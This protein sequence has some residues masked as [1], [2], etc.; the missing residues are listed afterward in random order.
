MAHTI[1]GVKREGDNEVTET[2]EG[3][4]YGFTEHYHVVSDSPTHIMWEVMRDAVP[5]VA[6]V[7]YLPVNGLPLPGSTVSQDGICVCKTLTGARDER[8]PIK[9]TFTAT[10]S[11]QVEDSE[12]YTIGVDLE[13]P[14]IETAV[15]PRET[16][17]ETI[18]RNQ[19]EDKLGRPYTDGAAS[20]FSPSL[21]VEIERSKWNFTQY[22]PVYDG[23]LGAID[24][25]STTIAGLTGTVGVLTQ[26]DYT[27]GVAYPP[28][29]YHNSGGWTFLAFTD[30][31]VTFFN[32]AVNQSAF[33]GYG[34]F[35]LLLTV[36]KSVEGTF[37][38]KRRRKTSYNIL[39]DSQKHWDR[40][41]NAGPYFVAKEL[42]VD[43]DE[44]ANDVKYPYIYFTKDQED[45]SS[46]L[47]VDESGPLGS[48]NIILEVGGPDLIR[49]NHNIELQDG[50]PTGGITKVKTASGSYTYRANKLANPTQHYIEYMNRDVFEF[51]DYLRIR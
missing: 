32:G 36:R 1:I 4:V 43:G 22:E 7:P 3:I 46:N 10:W 6:T 31:T 42:D 20:L 24:S 2:R 9:W 12:L 37:Y 25:T 5:D 30:N 50:L 44:T 13:S 19:V 28:G 41:I 40:P 49:A 15:S 8:N 33:Q 27:G 51:S 26:A 11:N 17:F 45:D 48:R 34:A 29:V 21:Q 35:T 18:L 14:N 39:H 47:V 23:S 16:L 38:G